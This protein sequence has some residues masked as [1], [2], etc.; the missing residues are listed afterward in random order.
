MARLLVVDDEPQM[1][2]AYK[3]TF[4][5]FSDASPAW[6]LEDGDLDVLSE[7]LFSEPA[8][9]K[10]S[11]HDFDVQYCSQGDEA[12]RKVEEALA[13]GQPFSVILLDMRM[14]PGIDGKETARRVRALDR[15]IN[16]VIVTGYSDHSP[17]TVAEVAGPIDKLFYITKPF[18][19]VEIRQLAISLD[20]RWRLE[21]EQK[22][23]EQ[24][25]RAKDM[26]LQLAM[27][28]SGLG[29]WSWNAL[30]DAMILSSRAASFFGLHP[31]SSMTWSEL[32]R[33]LVDG[34]RERVQ[35]AMTAA[36]LNDE[37]F[38]L[39]Y[40]I[41]RPDNGQI[42]WLAQRARTEFSAEG[43]AIG[44]SGVV[45]DVTDERTALERERLLAREVD[46]R[47]KN[48][49]AVV[50]ALVR[51]TPFTSK[52]EYVATVTGR[53]HA[54]AR[55]HTLLSRNSWNGA[56]IEQIVREELAPFETTGSFEIQG[57]DVELSLEAAQPLSLLIHELTT[58]A[59][60]YGALSVP[61]G[62]VS[63]SWTVT[64]DGG[65]KLA[66]TETGGPRPPIAEISGF[67]T[68]LIRGAASQ[69]GGVVEQEWRPTGL[70]CTLSIATFQTKGFSTPNQTMFSRRQRTTRLKG[71]R[72]L[73]VE[74]EVLLAMETANHLAAAGATV[75]G[76]AN[77]LTAGLAMAAS[78]RIDGAVLDLNLGGQSAE[79]LLQF[80][81]R[82]E[83]PFIVITGYE[84]AGVQVPVLLRK[85]VEYPTLVETLSEQLAKIGPR[86]VAASSAR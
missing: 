19:R 44:L 71:S 66:W 70:H 63:V 52:E 29:D 40:R 43:E 74:D 39:E 82:M 6:P 25:Q 4:S 48:A 67:G 34:D 47:A 59:S 21:H 10:D 16:I 83:V 85:P 27:V 38:D 51:L 46:H 5:T 62:R 56:T 33:L 55:V 86:R 79:P 12:A 73:V 77:T 72:I 78:E 45:R 32:S 64:G 30:T 69:L 75:I 49:L 37:P 84:S 9:P 20:A 11:P 58:N 26:R 22:K 15:D 17:H 13:S 35:S 76:P 41:V 68:R 42:R 23:L 65:V 60:K 54:M 61:A 3:A 7:Q 18:D 50:Q 57:P 8:K 24:I 53:I 81:S 14:P 1:L 31:A 2:S 80:L 28:A 36:L